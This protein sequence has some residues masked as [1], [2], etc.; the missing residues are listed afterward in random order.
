M[1]GYSTV[2]KILHWVLAAFILVLLAFGNQLANSEPSFELIAKYNQH[3]IAGLLALLLIIWRLVERIRTKPTPPGGDTPTWEDRLARVVHIAFYVVLFAMPLSGWAASSASGQYPIIFGNQVPG[4]APQDPELAKTLFAAHGVIGK[5][6]LGL[7]AL[8]LIGL[9]KRLIAG[10][11]SP[12]ER[13][14][15]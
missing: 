10:D 15:G 5:M 4:I 11:N 12:I 6:L 8:H 7:F 14:L 2:S 3:K 9:F 13:M 1:T